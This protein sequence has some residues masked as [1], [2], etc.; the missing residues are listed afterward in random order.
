MLLN[1]Q[2]KGRCVFNKVRIQPVNLVF[3][4]WWMSDVKYRIYRGFVSSYPRL[5]LRRL[6]G[7]RI[8][9]N[10][11]TS[12]SL[13]LCFGWEIDRCRFIMYDLFYFYLVIEMVLLSHLLFLLQLVRDLP[14]PMIYITTIFTHIF[15][16]SRKIH[17]SSLQ[18]SYSISILIFSCSPKSNIFIIWQPLYKYFDCLY[19]LVF[20]ELV[21][22]SVKTFYDGHWLYLFL[23]NK[24]Y[25]WG[26]ICVW[27]V[28]FIIV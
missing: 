15:Q 20:E 26:I 27:R 11:N 17:I 22:G 16:L 4:G 2:F 23:R 13:Y 1:Q 25:S 12:L 19:I 9:F 5:S 3:G 14:I 24:I 6:S 28:E 21:A 18:I 10:P 8:I 7:W